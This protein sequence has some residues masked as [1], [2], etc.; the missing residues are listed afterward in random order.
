MEKF[1]INIVEKSG[2]FS[3]CYI[4]TKRSN[5]WRRLVVFKNTQKFETVTEAN[6]HINKNFIIDKDIIISKRIIKQ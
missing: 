5:S 2:N 1:R 3:H 6:D 4:Q